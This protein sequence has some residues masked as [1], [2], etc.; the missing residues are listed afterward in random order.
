MALYTV[1]WK[2]SASFVCVLSYWI[3]ILLSFHSKTCCRMPP[4]DSTWIKQL[5]IFVHSSFH[6]FLKSTCSTLVSVRLVYWAARLTTWLTDVL[7]VASDWSLKKEQIHYVLHT[8]YVWLHRKRWVFSIRCNNWLP[9][10]LAGVTSASLVCWLLVI[11][12]CLLL[13]FYIINNGDTGEEPHLRLHW[14]SM[15]A[16]KS[17]LPALMGLFHSSIPMKNPPH[18]LKNVDN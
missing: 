16:Y 10:P 18:V 1:L 7:T 15:Y 12:L 11:V 6:T 13:K 17:C 9:S 8:H 5:T 4:S 3:S 2:K 14:L